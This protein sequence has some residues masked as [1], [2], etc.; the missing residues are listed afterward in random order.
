VF[1]DEPTTNLD[2]EKRRN[3]VDQLQNL[4]GF[5]QLTVV[6]HDDAFESVT[7]HAITLEKVDGATEVK[8][9]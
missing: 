6:S 8:L 4:E 3:L 9:Q 7:E 2:Q 1:L 5:E